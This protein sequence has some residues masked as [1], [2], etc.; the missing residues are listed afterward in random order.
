MTL[1]S[2]LKYE[3]GKLDRVVAVMTYLRG[4]SGLMSSLLDSHPNVIATPD[5]ILTGFY[6]FWDRHGH[7]PPKELVPTFMDYYATIFNAREPSKCPRAGADFGGYSNFTNLGPDQD[8][9]LEVDREIFG[10]IILEIIGEHATVPRK[11]FFQALHAA[12]SQ[13]IGQDVT[14]PVIAYGLHIPKP[15]CI[16]P[17]MEDFPQAKFLQMVRNPI[18]SVGSLFRH[19]LVGVRSF[20][21]MGASV[22]TSAL[23]HGIPTLSGDAPNW[24]AIRLEDL[25]ENPR[26]TMEK[27]SRWLDIPWDE[28]LLASTINGKQWWNEKNTLKISGFST[29]IA[30]QRFEEFIPNFDR[31]RLEMLLGFKNRVW[32]YGQGKWKHGRLAQ[33]LAMPLILLPLKLE[34]LSIGASISATAPRPSLVSRISTTVSALYEGR[35]LLLRAWLH[36]LRRGSREVKLL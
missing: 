24:R 23:Y 3:V 15:E 2:T 9:C 26:E 12:Y 25:H 34:I 29:S 30:A 11:L 17:F 33:L 1:G 19:R 5:C 28:S 13:A 27:L 32:G 31:F 21:L 14:D 36:C 35:K 10:R 18:S 8:E 6:E 20:P 22:V 4:G 7:L 16:V